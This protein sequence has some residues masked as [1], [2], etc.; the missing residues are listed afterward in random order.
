MS[1]SLSAKF[2]LTAGISSM[3]STPSWSASAI[4]SSEYG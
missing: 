1:S 4:A 3:I 2:R